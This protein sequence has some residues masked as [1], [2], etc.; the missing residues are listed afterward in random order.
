MQVCLC[1]HELYHMHL[2]IIMHAV[3]FIVDGGWSN[4]TTTTEC[5][6]SCGG[7]TLTMSRSCDNPLRS[8]G[9]QRCSGASTKTLSCNT[10]CCQGKNYA[11]MPQQWFIFIA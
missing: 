2:Q 11:C 4:W 6:R 7:G 3:I 5:T 8:C 9:G 1:P 10:H